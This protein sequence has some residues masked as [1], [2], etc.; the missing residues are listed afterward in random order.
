MHCGHT[1]A[2]A[3]A[4]ARTAV[5]RKPLGGGLGLALVFDRDRAAESDHVGLAQ[6]VEQLVEHGGHRSRGWRAGLRV[7]AG[8]DRTHRCFGGVRH[9]VEPLAV[10]VLE[11]RF[12]HLTE[13]RQACAGA[14]ALS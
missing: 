13:L 7:H 2:R 12:D 6:G 14:E 9:R 8:V 3:I 4:L 11:D 10:H 1:D 5:W